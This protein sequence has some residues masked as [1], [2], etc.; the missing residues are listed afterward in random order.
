MQTLHVD[1]A[2]WFTSLDMIYYRDLQ[3]DHEQVARFAHSPADGSQI[4]L[5]PGDT[6]AIGS[7]PKTKG[8]T[9]RQNCLTQH[10]GQ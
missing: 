3:L 2:D 1:A 5:E 9:F 8:M 6:V 7:G 10:S 4:A